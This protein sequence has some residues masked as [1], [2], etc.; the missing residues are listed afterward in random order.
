MQTESTDNLLL[1][2]EDLEN[3]LLE[4]HQLIDAIREGEVDAFTIRKNGKSEIYPLQ[5]GDYAYRLLIEKIGEGALNLTED[6]L[7]VYCNTAFPGFL[8]LPYEKVIGSFI[9]EWVVE[10][11]RDVFRDLFQAALTGN[12]RGEIGFFIM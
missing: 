4:A 12:S 3:R 8:Q 9:F 10:E 2:V 5:S 7:I 11:Y 1:R 6:G